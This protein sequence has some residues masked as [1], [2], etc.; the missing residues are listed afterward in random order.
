MLGDKTNGLAE[1]MKSLEGIEEDTESTPL[2]SANEEKLKRSALLDLLADDMAYFIA[3]VAFIILI[4]GGGL[5]AYRSCL[6]A[7]LWYKCR[8]RCCHYGVAA[9]ATR[10][11]P[12]PSLLYCSRVIL[13]AA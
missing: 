12:I 1:M 13:L 10:S 9:V 3:L 8:R 11:P 7:L 4:F 6:L 5:G 2:M